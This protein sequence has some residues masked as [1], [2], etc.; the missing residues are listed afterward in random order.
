MFTRVRSRGRP[1]RHGPMRK[2]DREV[3]LAFEQRSS[4]DDRDAHDPPFGVVAAAVTLGCERR[5]GRR[6]RLTA[7]EVEHV[8]VGVI[9][10]AVESSQA[11]LMFMASIP[12]GDLPCP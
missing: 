3:P 5:V 9:A 6:S 10:G 11:I 12:A 4:I 8:A 2:R 1:P 7:G